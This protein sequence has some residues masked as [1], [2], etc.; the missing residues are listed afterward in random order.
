[1]IDWVGSVTVVDGLDVWDGSGDCGVA[2]SDMATPLVWWL[3]RLIYPTSRQHTPPATS[4]TRPDTIS[5]KNYDPRTA[6]SSL[7]SGANSCSHYSAPVHVG[8]I[9]GGQTKD[10]ETQIMFKVLE[11]E[12]HL[13]VNLGILRVTDGRPPTVVIHPQR[14]AQMTAYQQTRLKDGVQILSERIRQAINK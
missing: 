9:V 12:T 8:R 4:N 5:F 6:V 2:K 7:W 10:D 13:N 3:N 1:V 11:Y 14:I